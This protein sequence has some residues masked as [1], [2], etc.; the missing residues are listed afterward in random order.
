MERRQHRLYLPLWGVVILSILFS[1][2]AALAATLYE[3]SQ[4]KLGARAEKALPADYTFVVLGDSRDN[5]PVFRKALASAKSFSPLF[6]LHMGDYSSGGTLEETE[7]F[8]A[9]VREEVPEIPLFVV[10][11]NHEKRGV[12]EKT[13]G[14]RR[15][16][17]DLAR[18]GLRVVVADNADNNLL[19]EEMGYLREQL[20]SSR[21]STFVAMHVPPRTTRWSWHSFSNGAEELTRLLA[22]KRVNLAFYGHVHIYDRDEIRGVPSIISGGA[23]AP[24]TYVG[25]PGEAVHHII[26]VRVRDGAATATMVPLG[27]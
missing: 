2:P 5:D 25:Y 10:L 15:F 24:L 27:K 13:I 18:L 26:V 22:E 4:E 1:A 20:Q 7:H 23:G 8:L 12:F 11:G 3:N 16:T 19:P 9:M 21:R 17:L 6:I 14:P